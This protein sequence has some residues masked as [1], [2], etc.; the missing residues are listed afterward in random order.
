[1]SDLNVRVVPLGDER[2]DEAAALLARAFHDEPLYIYACPD[3]VA[4]AQWLPWH[5]R[6]SVWA[7]SLCGQLL[8]TAGHLDLHGY[9]LSL[10]EKNRRRV[11][12]YYCANL[13]CTSTF[14]NADLGYE[15]PRCGS[16]GI[17][18]EFK[19]GSVS[20][21]DLKEPILGYLD[22]IGRIF[23]RSCAEHFSLGDDIGFIIYR[24]SEPYSHESCEVCRANLSTPAS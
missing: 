2:G 4:R 5:F 21:N 12:R 6:W 23:C 15:C 22:S 8:G 14:W 24:T 3:P 17:I 20:E 10:M 1:M 9:V 18:S 11:V 13:K 19:S 16:L 7:G